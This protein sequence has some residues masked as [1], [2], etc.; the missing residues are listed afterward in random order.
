MDDGRQFSTSEY[1]PL[2]HRKGLQQARCSSGGSDHQGEACHERSLLL[3]RKEVTGV[4]ARR[5]QTPC[6]TAA[7][8]NG[9]LIQ[10]R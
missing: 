6:V 4:H 8:L 7:H 3:K 10:S 2:V 5:A 9:S 1:P